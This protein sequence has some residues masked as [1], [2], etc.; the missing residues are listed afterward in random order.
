MQILC[1]TFSLKRCALLTGKIQV[2]KVNNYSPLLKELR[3]GKSA[4]GDYIQCKFSLCSTGRTNGDGRRRVRFY[5]MANLGQAQTERFKIQSRNTFLT[6][7]R[8]WI[9][10]LVK[11]D[12]S[13]LVFVY[14]DLFG[15]ILTKF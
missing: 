4:W 7:L 8:D 2:N 12:A 14:F 11:I 1:L 6:S 9:E 3:D 15:Q 13:N 10:L 5:L